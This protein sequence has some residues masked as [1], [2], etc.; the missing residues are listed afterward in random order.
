MTRQFEACLACLL[1]SF[2]AISSFELL[3]YV[4]LRPGLGHVCPF[5]AN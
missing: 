1:L 3:L 4:M 2:R 5:D